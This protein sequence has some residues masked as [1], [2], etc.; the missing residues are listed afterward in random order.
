MF[1]GWSLGELCYYGKALITIMH[2]IH[3]QMHTCNSSH[4]AAVFQLCFLFILCC[5]LH[6][7]E[8]NNLVDADYSHV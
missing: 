3:T 5:S 2:V 8:V 6:F 1:V 4:I 7:W